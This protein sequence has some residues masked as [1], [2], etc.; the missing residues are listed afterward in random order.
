MGYR[1]MPSTFSTH[2]SLQ[3]LSCSFFNWAL[4]YFDAM[5][6]GNERPALW[7]LRDF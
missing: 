7:V 1:P 4:E 6:A 2:P 5:A 3:Y